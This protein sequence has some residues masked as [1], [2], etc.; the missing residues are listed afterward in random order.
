MLIM[1][2]LILILILMIG[3]VGLICHDTGVDLPGQGDGGGRG[4]HARLRHPGGKK[5]YLRNVNNFLQDALARLV[6]F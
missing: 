1:V 6:S 2:I 3:H 5:A 4:D